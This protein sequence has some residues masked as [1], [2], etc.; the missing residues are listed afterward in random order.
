MLQVR[1]IREVREKSGKNKQDWKSGKSQGIRSQVRE[2][3]V[4]EKLSVAIKTEEQFL[5]LC[6]LVGPFLQRLNTERP[7]SIV[8]ITATLYHLLEQVD[9]NVTHLNHIDSICDLLYHIK[10]MFVGDSMR[11][12]I[13]GIIRRLRPALQMRLRFI[14][15]L[16]IDEIAEPR[17]ETPTR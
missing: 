14:A 16:N 9:K 12:D 4:K 6:H 15:H 7:R 13:E 3:F 11:A 17:A 5:F 10:Y 8:E 1:E 2:K